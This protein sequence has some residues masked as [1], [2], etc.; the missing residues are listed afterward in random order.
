MQPCV[1]ASA[2]WGIHDKRW[3]DALVRIGYQPQL[4]RLGYEADSIDVLRSKIAE[5]VNEETPILAG[6][7]DR[8]TRE[9]LGLPGRLVGLSWGFDLHQ[10]VDA[11][12]L[13]DLD[14]L[15]IDSSA[16]LQIALDAGL[17]RHRITLLPWGIDLSKF[18]PEGSVADLSFWSVPH[19]APVVLSMRAHE[20]L[21]RIGDIIDAF[22]RIVPL[23]PGAHLVIGHSGSLTQKLKHQ[24]ADLG[25][26]N[27][28]HFIRT[29]PEHELAPLLRRAHCYIT[30]SE[31]DGT[32]VTLLQAM[33]CGTAV[34]ASDTPGNSEWVQPGLTGRT[35]PVGDI[36]QLAKQAAAS[37]T[38]DSS[39]MIKSALQLVRQEANWEVNIVRLK[40]ALEGS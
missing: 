30:A 2:S 12:W 34:V 24:I 4:F 26:Q 39:A 29:L 5:A 15:V 14:A 19:E 27:Q 35:F 38:G 23:A 6:P 3:R 36:Q 9:L 18:V 11:H 32:S 20:P 8:I 37:L 10:I 40:Q 7:L 33:A 31:V 21:Y 16:T 22:A 28:S 17:P 1:Y 25:I 13:R